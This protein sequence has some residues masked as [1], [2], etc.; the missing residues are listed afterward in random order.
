MAKPKNEQK[1]NLIIRNAKIKDIPD[2]QALCRKVYPKK[3]R[4]TQAELR[5]QISRFREGQ[6]VAVLNDEIVGYCASLVTTE[7]KAMRRHTWQD[8][9]G[10]A[11]CSTHNPKGDFLYG[12]EVFVDPDYRGIRIGE[13]FYRE[14]TRLCKD[15]GLKGIAF[16]GRMPLLRKKYKQVGSP[17]VYLQQVLDKKIRDPVINFQMRQGFEILGIIKDYL[18][19]DQAS[20]GCAI[21]MVWRNPNFA[22]QEAMSSEKRVNKTETIRVA[23]VQYMQREISSFSEFKKIITYFVD[24]VHD[25]RCDFVLFPELFTLQLLS[26][27]ATKLPPEEAILKLTSYTDKLKDFF[28]DLAVKYNTNIIAGSHPVKTSKDIVQ[29]ITFIFLRDG[30][31]HEQAK[32]HPTPDEKYWWNTTG[33][34]RLEP[35]ETDCGTIGVLICYDSEFPELAR[36]LVDQGADLLFVPFCTDQREGYLRVRYCCHARAVENQCYVILAGNVGN[37]PKVRSMDIQY[38]QSCILTPCDFAF[39]RDGIAAD[40]TPNVETVIFADLNLNSLYESRMSG[41]VI[42]LSDRRHDLFRVVWHE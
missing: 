23:A 8:I 10:N 3:D 13:R 6:F 37:L 7:K 35:I 38:G 30:T 42:N 19:E 26:I 29:N 34:N 15:L 22:A 11:Y 1:P 24:V 14:R 32:I 41:S 4:Y 20:M 40:S 25:Y 9:T 21:H 36:H 33:G 2:I 16:G 5:G 28:Q 17:E 12:V 31:I 18:P 27:E 39:A